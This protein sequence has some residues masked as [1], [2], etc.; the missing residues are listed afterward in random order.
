MVIIKKYIRK[1]RISNR[2]MSFNSHPRKYGMASTPI[3]HK[4]LINTANIRARIIGSLF[5]VNFDTK[6]LVFISKLYSVQLKCYSCSTI[7]ALNQLI[8]TEVRSYAH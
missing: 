3:P 8:T 5:R 1:P 6:D 4:N 2:M 7:I